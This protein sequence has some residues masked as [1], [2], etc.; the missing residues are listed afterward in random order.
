L[1]GEFLINKRIPTK[2][3]LSCHWV[4]IPGTNYC[5]GGCG[6][7]ESINHLFL[8]CNFFGCVWHSI[9]RW[10]GILTGTPADVVKQAQQ[11]EGSSVFRKDIH[12]CLQVIWM[13][14]IWVLRKER[15]ARNFRHAE[16]PLDQLFEHI[17]LHSW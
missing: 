6:N 1:Y 15:N 14:T 11:F 12:L 7:E 10:L 3:N 8:G 16:L 4:V 13:A 5:V 17:K 2:Y 9:R